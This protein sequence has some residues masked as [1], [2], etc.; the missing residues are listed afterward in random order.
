MPKP[1]IDHDHLAETVAEIAEAM[2][3]PADWGRPADPAPGCDPVD[4]H[5]F[6][7]AILTN[8][9]RMHEAGESRTAFPIQS[10]SKVVALELALRDIGETLWERVD[11]EP[12]GDPFNSIIDLERLQG[13]PRNPFINAGALVVVDAMLG[14][15]HGP[16]PV[17]RF[18]DDLL[19]GE[20]V[21]L[22]EEVARS[23][24]EGADMNRALAHLA[25]HFGNLNH[26]VD[27]VI[28]AYSRQCAVALDCAGLAR[29]GRFLMI[30]GPDG[31]ATRDG[32][33]ARRA[34]RIGALMMTCGQYDG[35]GD[36]AYR[37][38]LPAKSGVSGAIMAVAPRI[39]S[40]AVWAPGLDDNGNS[41]L[42]VLALEMLT[43]R[44]NW[45]VFGAV[46]TRAG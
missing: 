1:E 36:F 4:P 7:M 45:S 42:G 44:V 24:R 2:R 43:D 29:A 27:R 14:H 39:A 30:E 22:D 17:R 23:G 12:S 26:S 40:I 35:S 20:G 11:R 21:G 18:I 28:E 8:D 25:A 19:D 37:V 10:I 38:G 31:A 13:R 6:G 46:G 5:H 33:A 41:L 9:G 32:E 15:G 34:G 16:D 3:D